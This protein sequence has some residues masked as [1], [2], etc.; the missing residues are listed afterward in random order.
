[1]SWCDIYVCTQAMYLRAKLRRLPASWFIITWLPDIIWMGVVSVAT[2]WS[3]PGH[4]QCG[5]WSHSSVGGESYSFQEHTHDTTV[6]FDPSFSIPLRNLSLADGSISKME[7][8]LRMSV[9]RKGPP[10]LE[11]KNNAGSWSINNC[12]QTTNLPKC[13]ESSTNFYP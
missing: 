2:V 13:H 4:C 7:S 11:W 5:S 10:V 12:S 6:R 8:S 9:M 1:M 3:W